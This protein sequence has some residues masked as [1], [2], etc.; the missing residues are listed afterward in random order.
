MG[1]V[2]TLARRELAGLFFS[3]QAYVEGAA[4]LFCS[5]LWFFLAIF[6]PGREA[7]LRPLFEGMAF[8]LIFVAPLLTMRLMSEEYRSGT[9]ETLM[10]APVTELQVVLGK[11]LGVAVFYLVFLATTVSLLVLILFYGQPDMGV[12]MMGYLGMVLLGLAFLAV[13]L[14]SSTVTR[15]Q[16]LAFVVGALILLVFTVG[17]QWLGFHVPLLSNLAMKLSA[18]SYFRE[19]ARGVF[20]TRGVVFF[21]S[22]TVAFLLFSVK[23]LE[24]RRW[25]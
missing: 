25:K 22:L 5:S 17:M 24:S 14:F 16:A 18:V 12:A 3:P 11:F 19:F 1:K 13:G 23:S 10:T 2:L 9:I 21:L 8:I 6:E 4:F 7:T 15:H 20:D